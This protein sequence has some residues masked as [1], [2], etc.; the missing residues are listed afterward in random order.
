MNIQMKMFYYK[1]VYLR[2]NWHARM[3]AT[4]AVFRTSDNRRNLLV[5]HCL[6]RRKCWFV[7]IWNYIFC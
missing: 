2:E 4:H 1:A 7:V 3:Y 5:T 6:I